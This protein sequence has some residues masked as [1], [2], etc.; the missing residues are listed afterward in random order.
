MYIHEG[1]VYNLDGYEI[2]FDIG[3]QIVFQYLFMIFLKGILSRIRNSKKIFIHPVNIESIYVA[4]KKLEN[5]ICFL[6][7]RE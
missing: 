6:N 7:R 1:T 2:Y 5:N 3:I 4:L